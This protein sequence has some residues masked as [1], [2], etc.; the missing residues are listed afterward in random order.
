MKYNN[1]IVSSIN[2]MVREHSISKTPI[3]LWFTGLSGSGKTTLSEAVEKELSSLGFFSYLLDGDK[4]RSGLNSDLDFSEAG[5]R[6]NIRRVGEVAKLFVDSGQIV[7]A[8]FISPFIIDR[9]FVRSLFPNNKFIEIFI[10]CPLETCEKRDVKG[11]YRKARTGEIKYFTGIS[12][13]YERPLNPEILIKNGDDVEVKINVQ[14][15]LNYLN[16]EKII[17][18]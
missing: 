1:S 5:R 15:I 13:P 10:D 16:Q 9:N 14:K 18:F 3:C 4:I 2:N 17:E 7:L 6:E 12:S 11:L 8:S